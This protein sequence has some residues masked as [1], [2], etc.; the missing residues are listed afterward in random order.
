MI[1]LYSAYCGYLCSNAGDSCTQDIIEK[2]FDEQVEVESDVANI[3]STT[4]VSTGSIAQDI[5]DNY[6]GA[7]WGTGLM[8]ENRTVN[9]PKATVFAVRGKLTR[10]RWPQAK[11][12][13]LGD[14]GLLVDKLLPGHESVNKRYA[15]GIIPHYVDREN[16]GVREFLR[17]NR[18]DTTSIDVCG[19]LDDV[20][21]AIAECEYIISSSLH[22]CIFA[23]SLGVPNSWTILSDQISGGNF[24]YRDYYSVFGFDDPLPYGFSEQAKVSDILS[25]TDIYDRPGIEELKAGLIREWPFQ[26]YRL[27]ENSSEIVQEVVGK[28]EVEGEENV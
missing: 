25:L 1:K 10:N 4:L 26:V 24:K 7:I 5:P 23:D 8:F 3:L 27:A 21:F 19:R 6:E 17:R 22:G 12:A 18:K 13:V 28:T 16:M 9:T 20:L 14:P 11:D 2:I 15:V